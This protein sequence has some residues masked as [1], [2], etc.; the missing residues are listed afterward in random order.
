MLLTQYFRKPLIAQ[1]NGMD[2]PSGLLPEDQHI[3]RHIDPALYP[4]CK[5]LIC[6]TFV[7]SQSFPAWDFDPYCF[8]SVRSAAAR[9]RRAFLPVLSVS[10][11]LLC[12]FVLYFLAEKEKNTG[13][14]K[15][16][17]LIKY[18]SAVLWPRPAAHK[19]YAGYVGSAIT[20]S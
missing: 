1:G 12:E 15:G 5:L 18:L 6:H 16:C 20:A 7:P 19:S 2:K 3:F 9:A 14:A 10:Y 4:H 17:L 11:S 8:P 13:T